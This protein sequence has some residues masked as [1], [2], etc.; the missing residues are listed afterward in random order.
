MSLKELKQHIKNNTFQNFYVL[1]GPERYL[2]E[3]YYAFMKR[4]ITEDDV[5]GLNTTI[6][7][8]KTFNAEDF[9]LVAQ[10][11]PAMSQRRLIVINDLAAS[12]VKGDTKTEI[13][14]VLSD[15]PEYLTIIFNYTDPAYDPTSSAELKKLF[16]PCLICG[17]A[18]PGERELT[19]WIKRNVEAENRIIDDNVISYLLSVVSNDMSALKHEIHKLCAHAKTKN[20]TREDIDDVCI[21]TVEARVF[22]LGDALIFGRTGEAYTI[23]NILMRHSGESPIAILAYLISIFAN[24]LKLKAAQRDGVPLTVAMKEIGYRGNIKTA[25]KMLDRVD[26]DTL[27]K[28]ITMCRETDFKMKDSRVGQDVLMELFIAEAS[29]VIGKLK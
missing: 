10:S 18:R 23:T 21:P 13:S 5:L 1:W 28:L 15:P 27:K 9:A 20:I 8:A 25:S 16:A 24:L 2:R 14:A 4:T 11:Y 17:F 26:S 3:Y 22:S 7:D 6:Y 19:T 12:L 29:K